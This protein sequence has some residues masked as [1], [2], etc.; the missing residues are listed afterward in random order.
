MN[1]TYSFTKWK[2]AVILLFSMIFMFGI[3]SYAQNIKLSYKDTPL[4]TVLKEIT[5]QSGYSFAYSDAFAQYANDKVSCEITS[6]GEIAKVLNTLFAGKGITYKITGKQIILAPEEIA[7][8]K[9]VN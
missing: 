1:K 8:K 2:K 9:Q 3:E 6:D 7:I 5:R 4:K